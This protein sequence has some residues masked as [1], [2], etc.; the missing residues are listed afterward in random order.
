MIPS[1][2]PTKDRKVIKLVGLSLLMGFISS[3][4]SDTYLDPFPTAQ[5]E[6]KTTIQQER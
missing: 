1:I 5:A 4:S 3:A 2:R 6:E